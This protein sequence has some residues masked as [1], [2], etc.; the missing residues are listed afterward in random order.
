MPRPPAAFSPLTTTNVG[1]WRSRRI[2]R[3]SSS[4][5]RPSPPTMSPMNRML[6]A[7]EPLKDA[8][9]PP[10][11]G[12]GGPLSAASRSAILW[13]WW[14]AIERRAASGGGAALGPAGAPAAVAAGLVGGGES[15]GESAGDLHR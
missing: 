7:P 14:E 5:R 6:G 13:E 9:C 3:Q 8:S 12:V 10:A 1:A 4:V 11:A 2:G 15:R